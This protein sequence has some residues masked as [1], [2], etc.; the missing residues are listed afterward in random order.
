MEVWALEGFGAAYNLQEMLTSKSDDVIGR[1]QVI[2][3][4]ASHQTPSFGNPEAFRVMARELRALCINVGVYNV[5]RTS[6]FRGK[7]SL[8]QLT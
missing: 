7:G 6:L 2:D 8:S 1:M 5:D 3:S 4:I